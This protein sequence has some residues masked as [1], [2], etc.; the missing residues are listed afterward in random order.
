M[1]LMFSFCNCSDDVPLN[2]I[3][4]IYFDFFC[5]IR[6]GKFPSPLPRLGHTGVCRFSS[7][8][9][10]SFVHGIEAAEKR[11]FT[12][13]HLYCLEDIIDNTLDTLAIIFQFDLF[14]GRKK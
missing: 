13:S 2:I 9:L 5:L 8:S 12:S 11:F 4:L 7:N 6:L 1:L 14:I 10:M 3:I